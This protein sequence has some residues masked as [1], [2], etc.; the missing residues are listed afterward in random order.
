MT[1]SGRSAQDA[2]DR[3]LVADDER[4]TRMA[5]EFGLPKHGSTS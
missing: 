4:A 3:V 2:V 5:L 1:R